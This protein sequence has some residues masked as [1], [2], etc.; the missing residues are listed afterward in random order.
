MWQVLPPCKPAR[1]AEPLLPLPLSSWRRCQVVRFCAQAPLTLLPPLS[2]RDSIVRRRLGI[3]R[4]NWH[5]I[6]KIRMAL[7]HEDGCEEEDGKLD[8]AHFIY[9]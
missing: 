5:C 7:A 6:E 2:G 1:H 3:I 9:R 8:F 4:Q